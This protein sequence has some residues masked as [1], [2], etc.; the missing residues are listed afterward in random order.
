MTSDSRICLPLLDFLAEG[1]I[2][3]CCGARGSGADAEFIAQSLSH[4]RRPADSAWIRWHLPPLS[5]RLIHPI[6]PVSTEINRGIRHQS[7][8][9]ASPRRRPTPMNT[10]IEMSAIV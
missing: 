10:Y 3:G 4:R 5:M 8:L 9:A 1:S 2:P 7:A 6:Y